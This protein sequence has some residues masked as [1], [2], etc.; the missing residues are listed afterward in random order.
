MD[1]GTVVRQSLWSPRNVTDFRQHVTEA[2]LQLPIFFTQENGALGLSLDDAAHGRYQTLHD[3]RMPAPLGG[4]HTTYIRIL[5]CIVGL[6]LLR[7]ICF[8]D[9]GCALV[10]RLQRFQ[11]TSTDPRR[12]TL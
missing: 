8:D 6:V 5:V 11:E 3:A 7:G 10:A 2:P 4:K 9:A 1:I 12:N